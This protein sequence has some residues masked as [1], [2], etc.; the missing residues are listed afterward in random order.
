MKA[1][2]LIGHGGLEK[3]ILNNNLPVPE[4]AKYDVLI[5]VG[6]C[7]INNTDI[8][9]RMGTYGS[10][11]GKDEP[12]GWLRSSFQFPRI[13]GVDIA[14]R[15]K[16][17][18][19]G[20]DSERIGQRVVVDHNIYDQ[21]KGRKHVIL[22]GSERDGGFAEYCS[23]P[24]ENAIQISSEYSDIELAS[25]PCAYGTAE[26]VL[27][28]AAVTKNDTV[29]ITGA[30]GG[31]GS[32]LIQLA[33]M[34]GAT[35]ISIVSSG[36]EEMAIH[37]GSDFVINRESSIEVQINQIDKNGKI[38]V[39]ADVVG[40][41]MFPQLLNFMAYQGTYVSTGA[42]AS[43][44]VEFDLRTIYLNELRLIGSTGFSHGEFKKIVSY[45]ETKK[46][47]PVVAKT[48]PLDNIHQAQKD[49]IDKKFFGKLVLVP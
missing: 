10:K 2:Q 42:I 22:I 7:A 13:Q 21:S 40:G 49:F 16:S 3:L 38:T 28:K 24:S 8:W 18:G 23:V 37:L 35:V 41:Q 26:G 48:Y 32:A 17:V 15:I 45:I 12:T 1:I 5:K 9:T 29:L 19:P 47:K 6:A 36:K 34:R 31:V 33:K 4:P 20:V 44:I 43:P 46:I 30:S 11:Q 25:F 27:N 39:V 14:G